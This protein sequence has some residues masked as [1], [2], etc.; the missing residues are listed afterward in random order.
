MACEHVI[1]SYTIPVSDALPYEH[2]WLQMFEHYHIITKWQSLESFINMRANM[3][4]YSFILNQII[5]LI[6]IFYK[7]LISLILEF[8]TWNFRTFVIYE[9]EHKEDRQSNYSHLQRIM[10]TLRKWIKE[11]HRCLLNGACTFIFLSY[12]FSFI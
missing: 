8:I 11:N 4:K 9:I 2:E 3:S 6:D 7:I 1:Y 10:I 5:W 12:N